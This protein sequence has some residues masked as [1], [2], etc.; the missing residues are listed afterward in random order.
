M[1]YKRRQYAYQFKS[2]DAK[3]DFAGYGSVFDVIDSYRDVVRPGAFERTIAE[4][5]AK[6]R[7]PPV[8]WQ[9]IGS[10]PIGPHTDL[11]EDSKGL[12]NEGRMLIDDVQQAREA[13]ALTKSG[14][15]A[16]QSIG[17]DIFEGGIIHDDKSNT[18][19]LTA[20]DLWEISIATFPANPEAMVTEVKQ[21]FA[22]GQLPTLRQFEGMLRD[23]GCSRSQAVEIANAGLAKLLQRE[24]GAKPAAKDP[25]K[26]L[27]ATLARIETFDPHFN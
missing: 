23:A 15:I 4:W 26:A 24:A 2:L 20:I 18:W 17:Y 13:Y 5:K 3:G 11:R 1:S 7:F 19:S 9:H 6:G 21:L 22:K 12:Y 8:L 25:E 14:A 27:A 10:Q 16:G